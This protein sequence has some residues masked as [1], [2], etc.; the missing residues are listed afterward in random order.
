[1]ENYLIVLFDNKLKQKII[2][3]YITFKKAKEY[4][5][6]C[7]EKSNEVIFEKKIKNGKPCNY[8]IGLIEASSKQLVPVYMTDEM[9]RNVKVRMENSG[10]T[11]VNISKYK[12]EEEI[13]DV[14]KKE[15]ITSETLIRRYLKKDNIKMVSSLNNKVVIQND[16]EINLFS[17]KSQDESLRFIDCISNYFFKTKR[18][19]CIF[20]KDVSS[21]QRKYLFSMLE[22]KGYDRKILYRKFT[23]FPRLK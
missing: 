9:G 10:M 20:V 21:A 4:F 14:Q 23:T 13:F 5:E 18:G 7:L 1:M 15:K 8:E 19:D 11:L 3:K 6:N 22:T 2:K 16:D 12:I 17:F